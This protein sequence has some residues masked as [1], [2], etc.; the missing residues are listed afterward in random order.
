MQG[1]CFGCAEIAIISA[2]G[3]AGQALGPTETQGWPTVFIL[4]CPLGFS[5]EVKCSESCSVVPNSLQRHAL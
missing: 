2:L 1:M 5:P 3:G 4:K